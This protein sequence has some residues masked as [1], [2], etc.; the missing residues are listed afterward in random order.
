MRRNPLRSPYLWAL[1]AVVGI[2]FAAW[3]ARTGYHP[4]T[5]GTLAPDFTVT[6]MD[7]EP[8]SL[9]DYRD[10][11]VL[12]NVWATWCPP[13]RQEM[14]SMERLYKAL[15]GED[16][17]ILAVSVDAPEG[18]TDAA[19]NKGGNLAAFAKEFGLTFP[20]LHNPS[21]D[22]EDL[23]QTTGVPESF[24]I[25]KDGVIYKKVAGPSEWDLPV[26]QELVRRLLNS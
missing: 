3:H 8:V 23:Y 4:V 9:S 24:I 14:P 22:I 25:G 7:G 20:L 17:E 15:E 13:C 19:G 6:A 2:V 12:M 21:G 16:F 18:E 26:N 11:V 10:K 5:A 1:V